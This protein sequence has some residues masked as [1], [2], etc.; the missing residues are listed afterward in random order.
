MYDWANSVYNLVITT[1]FFPVYYTE[2]TG[3]S[4]FKRESS[5]FRKDLCEYRFIYLCPGIYIFALWQSLYPFFHP[6]QDYKRKQE[7]VYAILLHVRRLILQF[8]F[9]FLRAE[10]FGFGIIC[11]MAAAF[12]FYSSLVFY[13]SYLPEIAEEKDRDHVS[14][15]GFTY[16]Y[17]GSVIM[18]L[19]GFCPCIVLG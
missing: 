5:F 4:P 10:Y 15:K 6:S 1:T 18:Q 14:A 13:N 2:M 3:A 12:G 17:I 8:A 19:V 16:G 7:E 9:I 11:M